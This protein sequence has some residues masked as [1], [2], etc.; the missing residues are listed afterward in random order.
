MRIL[1]VAYQQLRRYGHT[2]VSWAQKLFFGLV[3]N[4]HFVQGFSDRDVAAFEA[5]LGIRELGIKRA[6]RRLIETAD[7]IEPDLLVVGHCDMIS[8]ATLA[9]I[10]QR[11]PGIAIAVCNVDPLFVPHNTAHLH[12]RCE[13]AD[14]VFVS[15]GVRELQ[16]FTGKRAR[17][18]Y[19]PNAVDE[20]IEVYD[21]SAKAELPVDLIYCSNATGHTKRLEDL[22]WLKTRLA[23]SLV[24]K[25]HGSFGEPPVW[26]R[27]YDRALANSKMS[28]NLNRQEGL[29]WYTSDRVAQLGGNGV[30]AFTNR[31]TGLDTLFPA[32]TLPYFDDL[33]DLVKRVNAFHADDAMRRAWA[34]NTRRFLHTEMNSTL[35][36][37]YVVEATLQQAY[38][39]DYVW[40]E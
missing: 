5:P 31:A 11:H 23:P 34:G 1:H 24:F 22:A 32:E 20:S 9:T 4:G 15:T 18:Y 14:A 3:R 37:R 10:R 12:E 16:P 38:S 28:L 26:G 17:L 19:M 30:L 13:I 33:D 35:V 29:Y 6:N 2:R 25:I 40:I 36:A 8:N 27:D 7:A 21:S 39:H